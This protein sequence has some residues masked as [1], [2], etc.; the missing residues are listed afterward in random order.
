MLHL[1]ATDSTE[2]MRNLIKDTHT[3]SKITTSLFTTVVHEQQELSLKIY[4]IRLTKLRPQEICH[5]EIT[6]QGHDVLQSE[7]RVP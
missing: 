3:L 2:K 6:A 5:H 1:S 4:L 7:N